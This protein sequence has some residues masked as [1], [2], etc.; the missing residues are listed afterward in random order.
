MKVQY[1]CDSNIIRNVYWRW[2]SDSGSKSLTIGNQKE[3][4]GQDYMVGSKCTTALEPSAPTSTFGSYRSKGIRYNGSCAPASQDNPFKIWGDSRTYLT[5]SIGLFGEDIEN[6]DDTDWAVTGRVSMGGNKTENSGFH[7]GAA[8]SYRH[9][10]Y[11]RITLRPGLQDVNRIPPGGTGCRHTG[12][13]PAVPVL[14]HKRPA[15]P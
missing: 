8:A 9:G 12:A 5:G 1:D 13:A 2:L 11:D 7:L 6:S 4:M 3:P 15:C 10:E 14:I